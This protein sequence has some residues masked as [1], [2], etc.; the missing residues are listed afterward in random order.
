MPPPITR[1][2]RKLPHIR[3]S[4]SVYFVTWR[5]HRKQREISELERSDVAASLRYFDG[6]RYQLHGFVVMNDHVHVM[7]EPLNGWPLETLVHSWKS[8]TAHRL[9]RLHG[10]KGAVWQDE[11]FDRVIRD[12]QEYCQKRDYI[13]ANPFKRW[14]DLDRYPW[15]WA[16]GW[17]SAE[18]QSGE[19]GGDACPTGLFQK[20]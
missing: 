5:C 7:V 14:P 10:R 19:T 20:A 11:S 8:F 1:Y 2:Y 16:I 15:V 4:H 3:M 18:T 9:Q 12:D 6:A 17:D 13:L